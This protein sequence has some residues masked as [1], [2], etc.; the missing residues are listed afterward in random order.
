[1]GASRPTV[2]RVLKMECGC[3]YQYSPDR[4][5]RGERQFECAHGRLW[6]IRA[7][8]SITSYESKDVTPVEDKNDG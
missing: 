7:I 3:L 1:M 5:V 6:R 8:T 4:F 2:S